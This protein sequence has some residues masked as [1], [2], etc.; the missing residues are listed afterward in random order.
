M[1]MTVDQTGQDRA[2]NGLDD[3]SI[4]AATRISSDVPMGSARPSRTAPD[5]W[6][7]SRRAW[8]P[9]RWR[10]GAPYIWR[11][12]AEGTERDR[13]HGL[14]GMIT[15]ASARW[16]SRDA[17]SASDPSSHFKPGKVHLGQGGHSNLLSELVVSATPNLSEGRMV[18]AVL[19][20]TRSSG[21]LSENYRTTSVGRISRRGR[22]RSSEIG[23]ETF[24]ALANI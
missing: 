23:D 22:P 1:D 2:A 7:A 13:L 21:D 19:S 24:R 8:R 18:A 14:R 3:T 16:S 4:R 12:A 9:W 17:W 6:K 15:T 10:S 5:G 20:S 11:A